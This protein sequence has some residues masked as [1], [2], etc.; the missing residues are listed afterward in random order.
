MTSAITSLLLGWDLAIPR[1]ISNG[2]VSYRVRLGLGFWSGPPTFSPL[3]EETYTYAG[4]TYPGGFIGDEIFM[5]PASADWHG[6][7]EGGLINTI[8]M[9]ETVD[10]EPSPGPT[11]ITLAVW[12]N[13]QEWD[14]PVANGLT[15]RVRLNDGTVLGSGQINANGTFTGRFV[16]VDQTFAGGIITQNAGFRS[17]LEVDP[18][19]VSN[20]TFRMKGV[21][22]V[23]RNFT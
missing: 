21:L 2:C 16:P 15:F 10:L 11:R 7:D 1:L 20:I 13:I 6:D 17:S 14:T 5:A 9:P 23:Y 8:P 4:G 12:L 19:V 22:S 18:A 3:L